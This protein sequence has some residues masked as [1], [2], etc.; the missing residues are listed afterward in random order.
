[1][2]T[3]P[4]GQEVLRK[5]G[6]KKVT[7][8]A[9]YTSDFRLPRMAY[10]ALVQSTVPAGRIQSFDFS[11][12]RASAGVVAI[13]THTN[14]PRLKPPGSMATGGE[15]AEKFFPLQDPEIFFW[16][17]HIAVIV[18]DSLERAE[19]AAAKVRVEYEKTPFEVNME[20]NP[21][22][23][24]D[25]KTAMGQKLQIAR[26]DFAA[27]MNAAEV[28][29]AETYRTPYFNHNPMEPHATLADWTD[30]GLT[31]YEPT[32]WVMG[33]RS[34][35]SKSFDMKP[36]KVRII[37][38]FVGGGFG[39]KGFSWP[40]TLAAAMA[41]R[42]ARRPVKLVLTR[43][44]MFTSVGHRGPTRQ[45]VELGART[46]VSR[47]SSTRRLPRRPSRATTWRPAGWRPRFYT[48]VRPF[49]YPTRWPG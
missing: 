18:A 24:F 44:Q 22:E 26:G 39:S 11:A 20:G 32:Q 38:P 46:G 15:F 28:V 34:V 31:I 21:A 3:S 36:E 33:L 43:A 10:G 41:S 16:G 19:D 25:P 40:H 1:M 30:E 47:R 2:S 49:Q 37:S 9:S 17:Q 14:A 48:S 12:V 35:V 23:V 4:L 13:V 5:D 29:V 42:E 6:L 45:A 7:G 27:G 8:T